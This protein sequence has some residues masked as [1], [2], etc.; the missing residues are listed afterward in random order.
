MKRVF[1][2]ACAVLV[3]ASC[4][5]QKREKTTG[6][7]A[8]TTVETPTANPPADVTAYQIPPV[9]AMFTDPESR[10]RWAVEHYWDNF[11]FTDTLTVENWSAYAEQAFVD[12]DYQLLANIPEEMGGEAIAVLFGKA[13]ADKDVFLKF[14]EVAEKYLFDPNSPYRN[15]E[16]YIATLNS[17]LANPALDEWERIRPAE[18]LRLA[19]KN[20]VGDRA[21]DFRYTLE[22]G[23]TGT[24]HGLKASYTLLFFNN[25]G[26]PTCRD[27]MDQIMASPYLAN[28]IGSGAL[29]VLAVYP[30]EDLAAWREYLPQMPEEWIVS[31]DATQKIKNDEL[32]DLKAIP[33]IYLLDADKRVMLKDVMSIPLIE[34]TIN[35]DK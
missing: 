16:L 33:T 32:Y 17:V 25:P 14:A 34:E 15:E 27:M 20:R 19:L 21:A 29:A 10:A 24:M 11:D 28:M 26:C 1:L 4:G 23:A 13:Q 7:G 2:M 18:Q 30:D 3:C 31:R 12:F 22:S 35:N 5:G 8:G 6:D 9:P